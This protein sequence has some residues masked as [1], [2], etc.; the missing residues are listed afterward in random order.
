MTK[1][2]DHIFLE[3]IPFLPRMTQ[4]STKTI[5]R[6]NEDDQKFQKNIPKI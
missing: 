1:F 3:N 5:T 4:N 2:D 6:K